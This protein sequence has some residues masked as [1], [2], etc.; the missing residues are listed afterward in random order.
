MGSKMTTELN[1]HLSHIKRRNIFGITKERFGARPK[2]WIV[3][4]YQ[5]NS[6]LTV[7]GN[8]IEI[9]CFV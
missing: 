3:Q 7:N 4:V 5:M 9:E 1:Q 2:L 8:W 6:Q